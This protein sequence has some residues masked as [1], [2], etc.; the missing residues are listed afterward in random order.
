VCV[1][2]KRRDPWLKR[3]INVHAG[4]QGPLAPA[5]HDTYGRCRRQQPDTNA[6]PVPVTWHRQQVDEIEAGLYTA[7]KRLTTIHGDRYDTKGN[8]KCW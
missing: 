6:L 7:V 8:A 5:A 4:V 1:H 3:V 2:T